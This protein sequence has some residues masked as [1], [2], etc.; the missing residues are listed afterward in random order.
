M[1]RQVTASLAALA[2]AAAP[3]FAQTYKT[4][5]PPA[6]TNAAT[7]AGLAREREIHERFARGVAA[8]ERGAWDAAVVEFRRILALA[9]PEP[10]GSTAR[11][12]LALAE[13]M[14]GHDDVAAGLLQEALHRDP[15]F[16]AAAANLVAV[17]LRRGDGAAARAAAERVVA[18]APDAARARYARGL[19]AL[20]NGDLPT[21]REDFRALAERNP[22]YAVAHYDLALVELRAGRNEPARFELDRALALSPGYARA[23]FALGTLLLRT[24]ER[25]EAREAFERCARDAADPALRAL[26]LELRNRI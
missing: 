22:A 24:G 7:L 11:Y 12:D 9:P 17:E 1:K 4:T 8:E 15:H 23:R 13:A 20:R 5:P 18:I 3:A 25:K 14:R 16:A 2:F 26:A 21:A 6:T 10:R 19:A